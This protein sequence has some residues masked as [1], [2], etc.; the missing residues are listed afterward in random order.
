MK[1]KKTLDN[2]SYAAKQISSCHHVY[3]FLFIVCL[4]EENDVLFL[5]CFVLFFLCVCVRVSANMAAM[6]CMSLLGCLFPMCGWA[7]VLTQNNPSPR[8]SA[9]ATAPLYSL[10]GEVCVCVREGEGERY[11]ERESVI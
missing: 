3:A 1:G 8:T 6:G 5:F 11:R 2:V 10:S 7:L 9:A 4:E